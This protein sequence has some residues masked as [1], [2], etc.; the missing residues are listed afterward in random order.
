[1]RKKRHNNYLWK[2]KKIAQDYT[3]F[4]DDQLIKCG[5]QAEKR[6][7]QRVANP[8]TQ[9]QAR[10]WTYGWNKA[11]GV[12]QGC[13]LCGA[14]T[15]RMPRKFLVFYEAWKVAN[16]ASSLPVEYDNISDPV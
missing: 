13:A 4:T 15:A 10:L 2:R 16:R 9:R 12:C 8:F 1:M 11:H 7:A 14:G 6:G 5:I 3:H